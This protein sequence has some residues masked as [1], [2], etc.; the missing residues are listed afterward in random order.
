VSHLAELAVRNLALIEQARVSFSPG[1]TVITGETGAGK[2][3]LIDALSLVMGWRADSGLVRHGAAGARVE[4]LFEHGGAEPLICVRELTAAGRSLARINDETATAGRLAATVGELVEVHG[5][6]DQQRLLNGASQCD[7]LDAFG[8]HAKLRQRVRA[9]VVAWRE[10]EAVLRELAVEP[11]E[12]ARRIELA[13]H[14]ADEIEAAGVT[15]GEVE[16]LQARVRA[17]ANSERVRS[18]L[19]EAYRL[20]AAD[21]GARDQAA[22]A[23]RATSQLAE[24]DTSLASLAERAAGLEAEL[25]DLALELGRTGAVAQATPVA[26]LE[27]RLS[28]LYGLLRKYGVDEAAVLAHGQAARVEADR[29]RGTQQQ[30][31]RREASARELEA[32]ARSAAADLHAARAAAADRLAAAATDAL[33]E[34]DFPAAAFSVALSA[35]ALDESGADEVAFMLAPN[36]GEPARSLARIASGGELSRVALALKS[37]LARADATPTLVFDEI[38]AGIGGRS[39]DP[40]GR[41][42]RSLARHHQV[43]CI[44]HLAQIAAYADAHLRIEKGEREGR[45][46]TV[47]RRLEGDQ[48]RTELAE[49]LAGAA[50]RDSALA[51]VDELLA[52]VDD[53]AAAS[54][55]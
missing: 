27:E 25:A 31:A 28:L 24:L 16:A 30:R 11:A 20:L 37:V 41:M 47:V 14:A 55:A 53:L 15:V 26:E 46:V 36:L 42:L 50:G 19:A 32:A 18:L 38:D 3:L 8:G 40:V 9:A 54:A 21:G 22:L 6:H 13:E 51:A 23:A 17:A 35:T 33:R 45:T 2:S 29:L 43:I 44:T 34:L 12:L 5:Q 52:R 4:A 10:N 1:F 7:L 48:R 39:A 49:M